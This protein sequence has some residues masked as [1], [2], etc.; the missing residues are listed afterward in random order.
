LLIALANLDDVI[1]TIRQSPDVETAKERLMSRFRLSERQTQAILDMQLRR[2]AALERQK[3]E[4]EQKQTLERIAQLE[5]LLANPKKILLVIREDIQQISEKYGDDR[6]TRIAREASEDFRE[7]DLVSDEFVL[8]SLTVRGY[9]K[10]M[11]ATAFRAQSRGGRGVTGHAT[12][13]EDEVL[14]FFSARTLDTV[15][16]FSNRGKVYSEKAYQIPDTDRT[17]R[18]IPIVNILS[19]EAGETITAALA[20]SQFDEGH[21]CM[22]ATRNGRIKRIALSEFTSVRP[23]GLI[24]MSLENSDDLGWVRQTNGQDE[25][26]LV[27]EQGKALRFSEDEVRPMG[28]NAGGVTAIH[29]SGK[30]HVTSME[31]VEPGGQLLII[32]THGYGKCTSLSE[33]PAKGRATGGVVTIDQKALPR[34]GLIT[35]ARVVQDADDLTIIS[36]GGVVLRTQVQDTPHTG[37]GARG[38]VLISLS[39]SD[40]VA[41]I[42]RIA[43]ADLRRVQAA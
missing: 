22:M 27:T 15:L 3:I 29:L 42:A 31:V 24:A 6:R 25:I 41:S 19:L 21:Y 33:Y 28:R 7:E 2:L 10:R 16:F 8:V 43:E 37:R 32:T 1:Q 23:S 17:A 26:I 12:K 14:F 13:E 34:I 40:S 9:V 35:A 18:G 20:V 30:D 39:S 38:S 36:T 5:N 4:D 11:A